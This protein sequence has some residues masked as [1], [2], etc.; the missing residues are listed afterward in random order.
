MPVLLLILTRWWKH[1]QNTLW[2]AETKSS[3]CKIILLLSALLPNK[4][5]SVSNL[6]PILDFCKP[7]NLAFLAFAK[8]AKFLDLWVT[9]N[10][11]NWELV[12]LTILLRNMPARSSEFCSSRP[13][14]NFGSPVFMIHM[15][16]KVHGKSCVLLCKNLFFRTKATQP[17]YFQMYF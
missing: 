9:S 4:R 12:A 13:N 1:L 16:V 14:H 15:Y 3:Y 8:V 10:L 17:K 11:E 2:S 7:L 5:K 6:L